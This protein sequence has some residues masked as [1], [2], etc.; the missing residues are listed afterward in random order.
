MRHALDEVN[1]G[2]SVSLEIRKAR[3][4]IEADLARVGNSETS[5]VSV[6]R[7]KN[8]ATLAALSAGNSKLIEAV[9]QR[10][11]ENQLLLCRALAIMQSVISTLSEGRGDSA[12]QTAAPEK[13]AAA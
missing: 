5:M 3:G 8:E 12:A 7:A 1:R 13:A 11:R 2:I 10:A 4:S 6:A 9:E